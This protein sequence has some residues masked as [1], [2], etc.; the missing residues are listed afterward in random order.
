M[1]VSIVRVERVTSAWSSE[2]WL[3]KVDRLEEDIS[4]KS[5][6]YRLVGVFGELQDIGHYSNRGKGVTLE[7]W[8]RR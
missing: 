7:R 1:E 3:V 8:C 2:E 4:D 6:K 5:Q